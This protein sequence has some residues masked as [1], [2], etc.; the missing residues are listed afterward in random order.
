MCEPAGERLGSDEAGL[1][2]VLDV[3][4]HERIGNAGEVRAA[5]EAGDHDVGILAGQFHLLLGLE[6]DDA[7]VQADVVQHGAE[8]VLAVG[9]GDCKF[10]GLRDGAA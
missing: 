8:G 10:D 3:V 4:A 9:G 2:A 7:L 5:A 1:L 6:T